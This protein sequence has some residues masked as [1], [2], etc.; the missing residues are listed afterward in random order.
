MLST[1]EREALYSKCNIPMKALDRAL[2]LIPFT[3]A[4]I[5]D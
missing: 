3:Q 5:M 1:Q 4:H 2:P